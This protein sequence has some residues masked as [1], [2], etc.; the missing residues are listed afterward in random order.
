MR[1]YDEH[2]DESDVVDR[3]RAD[4]SFPRTCRDDFL[5]GN[6]YRSFTQFH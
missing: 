5:S 3:R 2:Y 1:Q 4:C 6:C